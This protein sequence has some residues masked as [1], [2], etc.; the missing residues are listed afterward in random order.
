MI[1]ITDLNRISRVKHTYYL[2]AVPVFKK[3]GKELPV[4]G[5]PSCVFSVFIQRTVAVLFYYF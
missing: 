5:A 1:L 4:S 2:E 3:S